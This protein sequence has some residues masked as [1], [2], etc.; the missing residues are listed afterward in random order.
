MNFP[1]SSASSEDDL[2]DKRPVAP[3]EYT[4]DLAI[5]LLG[6]FGDDD[7][8]PPPEQVTMHEDG[9]QASRQGLRV[10][11]LSRGRARLLLL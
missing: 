6:L 2:T 11:P 5:P 1:V 8:N 3:I 9:A 7:Q 4:K 10:P